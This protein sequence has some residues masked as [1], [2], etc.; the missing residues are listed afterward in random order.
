LI[1]KEE[2][3]SILPSPGFRFFGW[4][5]PGKQVGK[6]DLSSSLRCKISEFLVLDMEKFDDLM[7][8]IHFTSMGKLIEKLWKK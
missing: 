2:T 6:E 7:K 4:M 8:V 3:H 5:N 1:E